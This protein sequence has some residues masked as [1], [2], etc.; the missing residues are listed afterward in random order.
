MRILWIAAAMCAATMLWMGCDTDNDDNV[1][2]PNAPLARQIDSLITA[3]LS[4]S[5]P[6][7]SA[8]A[9]V[10][11]PVRD[12]SWTGSA[13]EADPESNETMTDNHR[14]RL[15]SVTK[16]MTAAL[17]LR[18]MEEGAVELDSTAWHYLGDGVGVNF[19]SL[20]VWQG[21]TYGKS[22]TV[23]Q[24]LQHTSGLPDYVFD[25]PTNFLGLTEFL[26]YALANPDKQWEP[27]EMVQ[28]SYRHLDPIG[29]PGAEY[30][31]SDTGYV[32]L[33]LIAEVV[34]GQPL[35]QAYRHYIFAPLGMTQSYLHLH[36]SA[37]S[38]G[39]LSHAFFLS[40][41][42]DDYNT[43]FDWGGGGVVCS[44]SDLT[45][46]IRAIGGNSLFEN[47]TTTT[48][49]FDW[50]MTEPGIEYGMGIEK[51]TN[52]HGEFIGHPGAY[53]SFAYYWVERGISIAGTVNQL[54]G[55]VEGFLLD[56]VDVMK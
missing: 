4:P 20:H 14:F 53:G 56:V 41:D 9:K 38:G 19:D 5:I 11:D 51:R 15:A 27:Y 12:F 18:L 21:T 8:V 55:D 24:L 26:L 23:R 28:W 2:S 13:G 6:V 10:E 3:T 16:P 22:I 43:S 25:G 33:G 44:A 49:M 7:H 47:A 36:E 35:A 48:F 34:T 17:I 40:V 50:T 37:V 52:E 46:F 29:A 39:P 54:D 42:T 30:H 32:L 45:K 1:D 31:Y